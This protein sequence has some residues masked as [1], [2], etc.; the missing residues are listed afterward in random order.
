M[1]GFGAVAIAIALALTVAVAVKLTL[2]PRAPQPD[3]GPAARA[4]APLA[5]PPGITLQA[6]NLGEQSKR[7]AVA[8]EIFAD[9]RGMSLYWVDED[10][11]SGGAAAC[12]GDCAQSWAPA[13]APPGAA[14]ITDWSLVSRDDGAKQWALRGRPLYRF[15]ADAAIGDTKGDGA[16]G[17]A[18]HAAVFRPGAGIPLPDSVRVRVI[19][20]GGGAG[21]TDEVGMTLYELHADARLAAGHCKPGSECARRWTPFEAPAIAGRIGD[22]A[23]LARDDGITQWTYRGRAL[24]RFDEDREAGDV[25][26][27]GR[28]PRFDAAWIVRQ[29]MPAD[30]AI[31]RH[32]A[33]GEI[34]TLT[35]GKTLYQRDRPATGEGH[36]FRE[37]HGTAALGRSFGTATCGGDCLKSWPPYA[38]PAGALPS[39]YWDIVTRDDATRQ[40][41]YK[42]FALYTY[43]ADEPGDVGGT[44]LFELDRIDGSADVAA[45][46]ATR[47]LQ[48]GGA[49][50]GLG[51]GAFFWHAVIP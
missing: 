24:Y 5:T 31:R 19:G 6:R 33:L 43:A 2:P 3:T 9:A 49:L 27:M 8:E 34:L 18:W 16:G 30:A 42:G 23:P 10:S 38:A 7:G 22:F 32:A 48:P 44:N 25:R 13:I 29:F 28:D 47:Y 4:E 41:T 37:N 12:T 1:T 14:P 20:N 26:G 50:A 51:I 45:T 35:N 46:A 39:G 21:F 15:A 17:G 36:S 11:A 40:W